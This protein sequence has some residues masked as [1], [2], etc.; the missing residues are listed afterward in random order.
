MSTAVLPDLLVASAKSSPTTNDPPTKIFPKTSNVRVLVRQRS[1]S[2]DSRDI[3]GKNHDH[4]QHL[5]PSSTKRKTQQTPGLNLLSQRSPQQCPGSMPKILRRVDSKDDLSIAPSLHS[6]SSAT[7]TTTSSLPEISPRSVRKCQDDSL[8]HQKSVNVVSH[9]KMS[10][11]RV[12]VGLKTF[13]PRNKTVVIA[14]FFQP[15]VLVY[16]IIFLDILDQ[17]EVCR[18]YV[19]QTELIFQLRKRRALMVLDQKKLL[20]RQK[21]SK[22]LLVSPPLSPHQENA[23]LKR[24]KTMKKK[25]RRRT[26]AEAALQ[27]A[28]KWQADQKAEE[29]SPDDEDDIDLDSI[30]SLF[31]LNTKSAPSSFFPKVILKCL[32]TQKDAIG[33]D[34]RIQLMND[35]TLTPMTAF[36]TIPGDLKSVLPTFVDARVLIAQAKSLVSVH[37]VT[38]SLKASVDSAA[39]C[40]DHAHTDLEGLQEEVTTYVQ[41]DS[42]NPNVLK[43]RALWQSSINAIIKRNRIARRMRCNWGNLIKELITEKR[44]KDAVSSEA[45]ARRKGEGGFRKLKI[46]TRRKGIMA[47]SGDDSEE[48]SFSPQDMAQYR[49]EMAARKDLKLKLKLRKEQHAF[50][51]MKT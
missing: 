42:L 7:A 10:F 31:L 33:M 28:K 51:H 36:Y 15:I 16:E 34:Y 26:D 5:T 4:G 27:E 3:F 6:S 40:S 11:V 30:D 23:R 47:Q 41:E 18:L 20:Q 21:T 25:I 2:F 35:L 24:A 8:L 39:V 19:Y 12:Y 45:S 9:A 14:I 22:M 32:Q 46:R 38:R 49:E 44:E 17:E 48:S 43:W 29:L 37:N 50:A 13:L 1:H